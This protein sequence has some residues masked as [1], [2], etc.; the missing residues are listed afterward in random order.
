MHCTK[1]YSWKSKKP[2][3]FFHL[4][5]FVTFAG[6]QKHT[7]CCLFTFCERIQL[8]C[9]LFFSKLLI[10]W[11]FEKQK[12]FL[13]IVCTDTGLKFVSFLPFHLMESSQHLHQF[14]PGVWYKFFCRLK[15]CPK[16][17]NYKPF[18]PL[19]NRKLFWISLLLH[20]A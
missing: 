17:C 13:C 5:C 14:L 18:H 16:C 9:I 20:M 11:A 8:K 15:E 10:S 12:A 7:M 2:N 4:A 1:Y 6:K 19:N 3:I